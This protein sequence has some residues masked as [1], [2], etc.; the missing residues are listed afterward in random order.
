MT[1]TPSLAE[2]RA[3]GGRRALYFR[4][5]G[6]DELMVSPGRDIV[7]ADILALAAKSVVVSQYSTYIRGNREE[8][9]SKERINGQHE[10]R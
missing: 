6:G 5:A 4:H 7:T 1:E 8:R 3:S 2:R 10:G 9:T